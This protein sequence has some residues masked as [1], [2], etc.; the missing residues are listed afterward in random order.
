MKKLVS[1]RVVQ[2]FAL[3]CCCSSSALAHEIFSTRASGALLLSDGGYLVDELNWVGARFVLKEKAQ[4]QDLG[5]ELAAVSGGSFFA[6]VIRLPDF[7]PADKASHIPGFAPSVPG[8]EG[9]AL[10]KGV[11][12]LPASAYGDPYETIV[13]DVEDRVLDAGTY[14]VVFGSGAFLTQ[15]T[16]LVAATLEEETADAFF[17]AVDMSFS[18]HG[19]QW[20]G[21]SDSPDIYGARMVVFGEPALTIPEP[22][23]AGLFLAGL[24]VLGVRSRVRERA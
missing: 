22:E 2:L 6:A 5:I 11:V 9:S 15:G 10:A 18:G 19:V 3:V 7:N 8:L 17:T 12:S 23:V 20:L 24:A 4:I 13:F 14:G 1:L 16:G 21:F